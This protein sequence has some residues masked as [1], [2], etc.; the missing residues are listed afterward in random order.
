M[1]VKLKVNGTARSLEVESDEPLLYVLRDEFGLNGAKFG[2]GLQQCGTCMV[3]A[4]GEAVPT[5]VQPC[6]N[7]AEM[8]IQT[9]EGLANG[10]NLHPIQESFYKEQAAQCGYCL[11][12]MLIAGLALL[13]KNSNPD[14]EEVRS[15][16]D[17]VICRCGTQSRFIRAILK[18]AETN[19]NF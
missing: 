2:C 1:P 16:L 9:I 10:D 19:S 7:F 14:E 18:T 13:K 4:D 17:K 15:A 8:E 11:N 6:K 12:G 5:C 3:L